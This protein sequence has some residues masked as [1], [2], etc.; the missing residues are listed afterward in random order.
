M[1]KIT[2]HIVV[3]LMIVFAVGAILYYISNTIDPLYAVDKERI[4]S[5]I[6]K[7]EQIEAITIGHSGNRAIDFEVLGLNG[8]HL[9]KGGTDLFET[10]YVLE[11]IVPILP[12]LKVIFI[13]ISPYSAFHDNAAVNIRADL[14]SRYYIIYESLNNDRMI[15]NDYKNYFLAEISP[16]IRGDHWR[17]VV[18]KI[19]RELRN[20]FVGKQKMNT[21]NLD[22]FGK[23]IND[24]H[25]IDGGKELNWGIIHISLAQQVLES[26]P[27]IM[28]ESTST[29]EDIV[30]YCSDKNIKIIFFSPPAS[31]KYW[32]KIKSL[33]KKHYFEEGK[34]R[35]TAKFGQ[36]G[37]DYYDFSF[38][39]SISENEDYFL[40]E[41]HLN[42]FGAK[43]FS[44]LLEEE[45]EL[46]SLL[47]K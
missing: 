12:N 2:I 15:K 34:R 46:D 29:I 20:T 37:I 17:G 43:L 47:N 31:S 4:D 6:A 25:L 38:F 3:F 27:N 16:L 18:G 41:N 11:T 8:F 7:S 14:R 10:K 45:T 44:K 23:F 36:I 30:N 22:K 24:E 35:L 28:L 40:D 39:P 21:K 5:L 32:K 33:D 42:I 1:K 13:P 19:V 26:N 9:W